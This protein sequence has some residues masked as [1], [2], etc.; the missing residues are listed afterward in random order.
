[1]LDLADTSIRAYR[2]RSGK[3]SLH[4]CSYL[5]V[6]TNRRFSLDAYLSNIDCR[7][8][9]GD[10]TEIDFEHI[11]YSVS[12]VCLYEFDTMVHS[13]QASAVTNLTDIRNSVGRLKVTYELFHHPCMKPDSFERIVPIIKRYY[14][15]NGRIY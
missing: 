11:S 14:R 8:I 1:M 10:G 2:K 7:L 5:L 12:R 4:L 15:H 13:F 9:L 3:I 6:K